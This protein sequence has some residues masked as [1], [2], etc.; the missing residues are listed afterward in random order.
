MVSFLTGSLGCNANMGRFWF[1]MGRVG[2]ECY[3]PNFG[4]CK[5]LY[6]KLDD[7]DEFETTFEML[8]DYNVSIDEENE[9]AAT[10]GWS[11]EAKSTGSVSVPKK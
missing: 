8:E 7:P 2:Q 1:Y 5:R 3:V 9:G 10:V 4:N 6:C 11:K